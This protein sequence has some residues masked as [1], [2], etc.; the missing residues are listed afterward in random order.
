MLWCSI[1][2]NNGNIG[3]YTVYSQCISYTR[4]RDSD[5]AA[6]HRGDMPGMI[7][8]ATFLVM[9]INKSS[10]DLRMEPEFKKSNGCYLSH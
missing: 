5:L 9:A 1:I 3:L 8:R 10:G 4:I 7:T 6:I 2:H